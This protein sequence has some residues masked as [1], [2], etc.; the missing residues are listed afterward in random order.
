VNLHDAL[1]YASSNPPKWMF[2]RDCGNDW[3][4]GLVSKSYVEI[5]EHDRVGDLVVIT[6]QGTRALLDLEEMKY[7]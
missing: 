2:L 1:K 6:L 5:M 7:D 4:E 3:L